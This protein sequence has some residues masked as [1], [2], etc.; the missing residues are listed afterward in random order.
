MKLK[1]IFSVLFTV[2]LWTTNTSMAQTIKT[3]NGPL[4]KPQSMICSIN[5]RRTIN[6]TYQYYED[7]DGKR[8]WHGPFRARVNTGVIL[9]MGVMNTGYNLDYGLRLRFE[10]KIAKRQV[11]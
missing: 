3:Y 7:S 4:E 9:S 2:S 5:D 11:Y 8:I 10:R 6:A 1:A